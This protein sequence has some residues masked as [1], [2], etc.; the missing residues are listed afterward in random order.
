MKE[1]SGAE[2]PLRWFVARTRGSQ[3]LSLRAKLS[4]LGVN[5]FIPTKEEYRVRRGH[6]TKVEV[7]LI[8]NMI[9]V[10]STKE[11]AC[12]LAN[13]RGLPLYYVVD[14]FTGSMLVVP[15]RQMENFIQV[16]SLAPD[17]ICIDSVPLVP[18]TRV[19]IAEGELA[20]I[21]GEVLELPTAT[22][23]VVSVGRLLC[24]KLKLAKES[25]EPIV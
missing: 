18:G 17:S 7:P 4:S 25:L 10:Q 13:G 1:G 15:D 23:V 21:E 11:V 3:E 24:A 16:V 12:A 5:Y 8:P 2:Q 22:Y 6:R 9:F 14:R 19:R 20:G